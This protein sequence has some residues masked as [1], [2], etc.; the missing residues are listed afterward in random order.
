MK[1][2]YSSTSP[3]VRKVTVTALECGLDDK[4]E[5]IS[6]NTTDPDLLRDNPLAK[7][8]A[9]VTDE[10][11]ALCESPVICDYLDSLHQGDKLHPPAGPERWRALNLAALADGVMDAAILRIQELR[12]RPENKRSDKVVGM[13]KSK[14][15]ETLDLLESKAAAGA[16]DGQVTIGELALA[17]ALGYLDFRFGDDAWRTGRPAL[18]AWYEKISQRP[19]LQATVPQDPA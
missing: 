12:L 8:P 6:T 2:R 5:R 9:L 19:S 10:G 3:Y 15:A 13:Q 16:L 1:L 4:I 11:M 17:C 14:I 18:T 7:V